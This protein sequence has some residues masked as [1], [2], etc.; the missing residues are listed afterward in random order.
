MESNHDEDSG[1]NQKIMEIA[2][3]LG[4]CKR[5]RQHADKLLVILTLTIASFVQTPLDNI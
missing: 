5:I 3:T 2:K 4:K 1:R